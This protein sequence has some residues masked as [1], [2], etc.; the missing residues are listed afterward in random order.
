MIEPMAVRVGII[1]SSQLRPPVYSQQSLSNRRSPHSIRNVVGLLLT[2]CIVAG[3]AGV[4]AAHDGNAH[5]GTDKGK[6]KPAW[7]SLISE[8]NTSKNAGVKDGNQSPPPITTRMSAAAGGQWSAAESWPVLAV[9]AALLPNGKVIAWDATPDDFDE[10][11]HTASSVTTRVTLWD[12]ETNT[13]TSTNNDTDTDLFCAGSA[14][15]WDGRILFAG[16]DS[17][18][19]G[20]NG[21]LSNANI[22]NPD[23][24]TWERVDN[25]H[26]PR[27]Y[28]SVAAL[29]NGEML[30]LGGSY[31]PTPL[32]E[33]FQLDQHWRDLPIVPPYSLSGDYQWIQSGPDGDVLY[34][35][36]HDLISTID[37]AGSGN[38]EVNSIRDN[39]GYRGYGSYAMYE[40]GRILVSGGG[41]SLDSS[42][43]VDAERNQ[44]VQT[45]SMNFGRRQHNLT[46]LADGSVL[47][48]GGNSSGS[49]LVDLFTGVLTPEIWNP[50]NGQWRT[51]NPMQ[52]DRQYH[53]IALLLPDGRVL[54][55]GGGYCGVCHFLAYHEQNAEIYTP[56]YL[57]N[58]N[59]G[60]AARPQIT[61]APDWVNYGRE[62]DVSMGSG[63]G[64]EKVH[65]IKL[66][67]VTHSENQDQRLVPLSFSQNGNQLRIAAPADRNL[68][69]PGHYMLFVVRNGVPSV[70][71]MVQVGQPLLQSG[72]S[73]RN[74]IARGETQWYAVDSDGS[75]A[76]L[77]A[78]IGQHTGDLDLLIVDGDTDILTAS[79]NNAECVSRNPGPD[80]EWCSTEL[81]GSGTWFVGV[82]AK[83]DAS[84]SM[85]VATTSGEPASIDVLLGQVNGIDNQIELERANFDISALDRPTVPAGL[86]SQVYSTSAAE[87]FWDASIDNNL[88]A[89]YE[90]FRDDAL[91][92]RG[93]RR[94]LFQS[95][96]QSGRTYRY[97]IRA[98][99]DEG[100]FSDFSATHF[101]ST[102]G[103]VSQPIANPDQ[104][105]LADEIPQG[106]LPESPQLVADAVIVAP[107]Q[108]EPTPPQVPVP[109]NAPSVPQRLR[110]LVYSVTA[111]ELFWDASSDDVLVAGYEIYRDGEFLTG[112]DMRTLYQPDLQPGRSYN[113]R[114]RAYDNEGNRSGFSDSLVLSTANAPQQPEQNTSV[115]VAE[116]EI[117][118][119]TESDAG[120]PPL[121]A[122]EPQ[123]QPE[124]E[125]APEPATPAETIVFTLINARTDTVVERYNNLVNGSVIDLDEVGETQLNIEAVVIGING[126]SRVQFDFNGQSGIR[127]ESLFPYA[128]FGDHSGDY[129]P[130]PLGVGEQNLTARVFTGSEVAASRTIGFTVRR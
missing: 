22:Y 89:G 111:A 120:V 125:V 10:D 42:I 69:P 70:S 48:T 126:I 40:P 49:E 39:A 73:V 20:R 83:E 127:N 5:N 107:E 112:G 51:V 67:S 23:S 109:Q 128:L 36:P 31:S 80:K 26:A 13:H 32:A 92:I 96:L 25:M 21:P 27:W 72:Q 9:H 29:P 130:M 87:I 121:A 65:M 4:S 63:D 46:I 41:N 38:W 47:A 115:M 30:T 94:S 99:D 12:P 58:A 3:Y 86:R 11:P 93:D 88:V 7:T 114:I 37:T 55:A 64:I 59:G 54:S 74:S 113:Y 129:I 53:S 56:P 122:A 43:I 57:L 117:P 34:F 35:G 110:S 104:P 14:H 60:L 45:S 90:V 106:P 116:A 77:S 97:R 44:V 123:P 15:M 95:D 103:P 118:A 76:F 6:K 119:A 28:S 24:N 50:N 62:F 16:G 71:A 101:L 2:G 19:S 124:P 75:N 1:R 100:N 81:S 17:G 33:V 66:G 61:S 68:A 85:L 8:S 82:E 102:S 91:L 78:V 79:S 18:N 52:I 98:Y 105:L 84:Y 108:G